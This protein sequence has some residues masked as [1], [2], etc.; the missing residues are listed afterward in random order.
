MQRFGKGFIALALAGLSFAGCKKEAPP[1][2]AAD[3]TVPPPAPVAP[4]LTTITLGSAI[5][6][7]RQIAAVK[8]TFGLRDTI[9]VSVATQ[10]SG[11]NQKLKAVWT[12]G[13]E[14]VRADSL[15]LNFNGPTVSEFHIS[16]PRAWPKGAYRVAVSL[17]DGPPQTRDFVVR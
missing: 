9:Y 1:P 4:Q 17:N 16:R 7:D 2:P 11:D 8:D 6:A 13:T 14:T 5:G 10:G 3:T 12:F 15:M